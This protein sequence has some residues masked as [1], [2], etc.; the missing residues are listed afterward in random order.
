M[1]QSLTHRKRKIYS[2]IMVTM[3]P[4][5]ITHNNHGNDPTKSESLSQPNNVF[6]AFIKH[7]VKGHLITPL[8]S[9]VWLLVGWTKINRKIIHVKTSDYTYIQICIFVCIYIYTY[10]SLLN[11]YIYICS[12]IIIY[13]GPVPS[14]DMQTPP[15]PSEVAIITWKMCTVLKRMKNHTSDFFDF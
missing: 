10:K 3:A 13:T 6:K 8:L 7:R 12:K 15:L 11:K 2:I 9:M 14:K 1:D 4:C 5:P